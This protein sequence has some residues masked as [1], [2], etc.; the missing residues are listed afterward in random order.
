M[1]HSAKVA[2]LLSVVILALSKEALP[3]LR[4]AFFVECYDLDSVKYLFAECYT[5]QSD[6][7]TPFIFIFAIPSKQTKDIT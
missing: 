6:Q 4:C 7:Y 3:V 5:R 1:R 2:S